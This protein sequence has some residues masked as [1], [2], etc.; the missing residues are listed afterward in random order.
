MRYRRSPITAQLLLAAAVFCAL[1]VTLLMRLESWHLD[2]LWTKISM[3]ASLFY[4]WPGL[5][6]IGS[7]HAFKEFMFTE[8][9]C[10]ARLFCNWEILTGN[11]VMIFSPSC[12]SKRVWLYFFLWNINYILKNVG[13]Q[14]VLVP[15]HLIIIFLSIQWKS[16]GKK[17]FG[18]Y[19]SSKYQSFMF[20]R[21]KKISWFWNE[22]RVS[23]CWPIFHFWVDYPFKTCLAWGGI[24][25]YYNE[26][27]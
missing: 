9:L 23:K 11:S 8:S 17:L 24:D 4:S 7:L 15:I 20:H 16:V 22:M 2:A 13:N 3:E 26:Y 12:R 14:T 18:N 19:H 5:F 21:R 6:F 27:Y 10:W 25:Y 1:S